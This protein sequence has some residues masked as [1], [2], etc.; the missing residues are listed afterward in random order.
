MMNELSYHIEF[1]LVD[2]RRDGEGY[3]GAGGQ[4]KVGV[5]DGAILPFTDCRGA[6]KARPE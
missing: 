6:V 1:S 3:D 4:C 2:D 5:D